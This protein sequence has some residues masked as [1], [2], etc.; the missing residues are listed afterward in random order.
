MATPPGLI[1]SVS[2]I[3]GIIGD[4]LTPD[5]ACRFAMAL[6]SHLQGGPVVL[7]RD[8]RPSGDMLRHA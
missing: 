3:R 7:G 6:G 8:S 5:V 4:S 2:G 1:V